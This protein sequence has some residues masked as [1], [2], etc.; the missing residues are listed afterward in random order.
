MRGNGYKAAIGGFCDG[1]ACDLDGVKE[2][3]A[4]VAAL[5]AR[6]KRPIERVELDINRAYLA[7]WRPSR[8]RV[9]NL[10]DDE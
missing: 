8:S 4:E 3:H 5:A 9:F 10:L 6:F 2:R 1:G 7:S